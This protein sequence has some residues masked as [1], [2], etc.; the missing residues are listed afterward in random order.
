MVFTRNFV[1]IRVTPTQ[2]PILGLR[3]ALLGAYRLKKG[4]NAR[5]YYTTSVREY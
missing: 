3:F 2:V 1:S 5:S 4:Q